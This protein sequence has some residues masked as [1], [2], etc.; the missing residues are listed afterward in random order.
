MPASTGQCR[1]SR[2]SAAVLAGALACGCSA[3]PAPIV[4]HQSP[5]ESVRLMFDPRSG[6]GHSHP[7][8]LTLEQMT[9]LLKGLRVKDRDV[10]G[11]F[12]LLAEREG[13]PALS[14]A[15]VAALAPHLIAALK[16]ASPR[17]IATF[18][19]VGF[20]SG[21]GRT[22]TSGGVF[23][24]DGRFYVLLANDRTTPGSVQYENTHEIDTSDQPLLPIARFKFTVGFSPPEARI[25]NDLAR[26]LDGY[27]PAYLDGSKQVVIDLAKLPAGP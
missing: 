24:R 17:D 7:V 9:A 12:G 1:V 10:V 11:G 27:D 14:S 15:E 19:V 2:L 5:R 21:R 13:A 22:V 23:V 26:K 25:P 3:G 4:I 6:G 8:T 18:Y 16:K 20:E